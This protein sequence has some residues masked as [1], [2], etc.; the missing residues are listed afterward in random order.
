VTAARVVLAIALA[1]GG[2]AAEPATRPLP[3]P[4]TCPTPEARHDRVVDDSRVARRPASRGER[5]I[6]ARGP[7]RFGLGDEIYFAAG[8][9]RIRSRERAVVAAVVDRWQLHPQW[10]LRVIGHA[11]KV[12]DGRGSRRLSQLRADRVK[13]ALVAAGVPAAQI[14]AVGV[15]ADAPGLH[16]TASRRVEFEVVVDAR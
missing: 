15:G 13:A 8:R 12:G 7:A 14:E 11:A 1:A 4:C 16:P 9:A 10:R 5:A 3:E 6:R 2:A